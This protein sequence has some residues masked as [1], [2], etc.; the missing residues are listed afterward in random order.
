M[1]AIDGAG[2]MHRIRARPAHW[3]RLISDGWRFLPENRPWDADER[4]WA[5]QALGI[6]D[7]GPSLVD[8]D[9]GWLKRRAME[10]CQTGRVTL[11]ASD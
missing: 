7:V 1:F 4:E 10:Y 3:E 8:A 2:N 11:T 9:D 5:V 6:Y